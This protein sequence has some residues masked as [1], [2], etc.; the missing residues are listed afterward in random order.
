ML[1]T[2]VP[3]NAHVQLKM[4]G[5]LHV[6]QG[7]SPIQINGRKDQ[8]R[9]RVCNGKDTI[10]HHEE[11]NSNSMPG[12]GM[13]SITQ[14]TYSE[15]MYRLS[16]SFRMSSNKRLDQAVSPLLHQKDICTPSFLSVLAALFRSLE[17]HDSGLTGS[18]G[19][20]ELQKTNTMV[21]HAWQA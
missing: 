21:A 18:D 12:N 10:L 3:G 4:Q 9:K 7:G 2:H 20:L 6:V 11:P 17:P 19:L 8:D 13:A 16:L 5:G 15:H 1:P 14:L